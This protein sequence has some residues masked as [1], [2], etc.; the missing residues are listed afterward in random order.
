VCVTSQN[1][2]ITDKSSTCYLYWENPDVFLT[3]LNQ[4]IKYASI[5]WR[6][7]RET[8]YWK[9]KTKMLKWKTLTIRYTSAGKIGN[10]FISCR[11]VKEY[12]YATHFVQ[13]RPWRSSLWNVSFL[14]CQKCRRRRLQTSSTLFGNGKHHLP[15][16]K[17]K[18][19]MKHFNY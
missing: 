2:E 1:I 5:C 7:W 15:A 6:I 10:L 9:G 11:R 4:K 19:K 18:E 13:S 8:K 14:P 3:L 16:I 17:M 12:V